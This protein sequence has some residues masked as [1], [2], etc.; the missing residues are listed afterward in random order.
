MHLPESIT[1]C[2]MSW[3]G[4]KTDEIAVNEA[5]QVEPEQPDNGNCTVFDYVKAGVVT[6]VYGYVIDL[7]VRNPVPN[8]TT[9][10]EKIF[11]GKEF[12]YIG[13]VLT[14]VGLMTSIS[15]LTDRNVS[16]GRRLCKLYIGSMTIVT[17]GL[18]YMRGCS[19][20]DAPNR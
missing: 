14:G 6:L 4:P 9:L 11:A 17:G 13:G 18:V 12:T 2:L 15:A 10:N 5:P 7:Q 8:R 3:F 20:L 16:F 19:V 1:S